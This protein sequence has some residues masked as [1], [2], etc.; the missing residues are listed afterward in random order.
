MTSD[1]KEQLREIVQGHLT[2]GLLR[3]QHARNIAGSKADNDILNNMDIS[4]A[5]FAQAEL[6]IKRLLG[7]EI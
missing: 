7:V 3:L 4:L 5:A 1:E 2:D 6:K